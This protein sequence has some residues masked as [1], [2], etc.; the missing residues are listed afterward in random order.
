MRVVPVANRSFVNAYAM[1][2]IVDP[3]GESAATASAS[4]PGAA[5]PAFATG[6]RRMPLNRALSRATWK[7]TDGRPSKSASGPDRYPHAAKY[8][9]PESNSCFT[10]R[11]SYAAWYVSPTMRSA[12]W[13]P[14]LLRV[15]P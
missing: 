8:S 1:I 10:I 9:A 7:L 11:A 15:F 2:R 4:T 3:S 12:R 14:F 5:L 6:R 13:S